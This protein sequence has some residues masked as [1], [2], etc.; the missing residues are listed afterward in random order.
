MNLIIQLF[1]FIL[2]I[3]IIIIITFVMEWPHV[4][5]A[6]ALLNPTQENNT[7]VNI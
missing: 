1:N 6:P 2:L 7:S 4:Q 3:I 5:D